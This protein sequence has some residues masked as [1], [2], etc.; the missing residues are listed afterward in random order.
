M[1]TV[2][3]ILL[4][5]KGRR[6]WFL[7]KKDLFASGN[8]SCKVSFGIFVLFIYFCFI[9]SKLKRLK[10]YILTIAS[11]INPYNIVEHFKNVCKICFKAFLSKNYNS[12]WFHQNLILISAFKR[13]FKSI[14]LKLHSEADCCYFKQKIPSLRYFRF[15]RL[16]F[17]IDT[18]MI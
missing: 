15:Q 13:F 3:Y 8:P 5:E 7:I 9:D 4:E 12:Q 18:K 1:L 2:L 16:N 10:R 6:H 17:Y 14:N 11:G